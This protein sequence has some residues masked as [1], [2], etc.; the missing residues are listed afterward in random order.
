MINADITR[1]I[2]VEVD[3]VK[4]TICK[5]LSPPE[6]SRVGGVDHSWHTD[7]INIM[8]ADVKALGRGEI[9]ALDIAAPCE[10]FCFL[11]LLPSKYGKKSKNPRPG[12]Q[13]PKG[14]VLVQCLEVASWVLKFNPDCDVFNENIKFDDL[15]GDFWPEDEDPDEFINALRRW[16]SEDGDEG[17]A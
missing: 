17:A 14:Q 9:V 5:T 1:S 7:V 10:D 3:P 13:G 11:R 12:L 4:R 15:K 8:G 2:G 6:S 16:R